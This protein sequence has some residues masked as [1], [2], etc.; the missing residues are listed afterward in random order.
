MKFKI[1]SVKLPVILPLV[2]I[3][4]PKIIPNVNG[5]RLILSIKNPKININQYLL[6]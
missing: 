6:K 3:Y 1:L 4:I 5:N 2:I